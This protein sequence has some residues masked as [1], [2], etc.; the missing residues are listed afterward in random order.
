M[1]GYLEQFIA[2]AN[3][4]KLSVLVAMIF[5]NFILGLAVSIY[6]KTF[7]LKAVA[8]FMLTRVLP[9]VLSYMAVVII[10][11][12]QPAWEVAVT[13]AWGVIILAL[14][15]AILAKLKEIGI[16]IPDFLAGEKE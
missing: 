3:G 16:N 10:A 7:R 12:V 15:G 14:V 9:Y 2:L 4:T 13:V 1:E 6:K 11:V 8:D 5:A